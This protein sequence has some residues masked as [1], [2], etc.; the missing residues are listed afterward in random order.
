[1]LFGGT[2]TTQVLIATSR[3]MP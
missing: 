1:M 3:L 2:K